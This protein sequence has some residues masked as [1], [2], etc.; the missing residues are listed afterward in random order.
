MYRAIIISDEEYLDEEINHV[1]NSLINNGYPSSLIDHRVNIMRMKILNNNNIKDDKSRMIMPY[2]GPVT[3]HLTTYLRRKL[4]C[5]FGFIPGQKVGNKICSHKQKEPPQKIGVYKIDCEEIS[6]KSSYIGETS[7]PLQQRLKEH[8]RDIKNKDEKSALATHIYLNPTHCINPESAT[9]L[10][11]ERRYF[12]RKFLEGLHIRNTEN[13]M[14]RDTGMDI[15]PIW[16][17]L[18]LPLMK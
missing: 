14:N 18:I 16:T 15:N 2:M 11:S 13:N 6:C 7:R 8:E 1:K 17:A 3:H 5:S 4:N 12:H 10:S 9:L